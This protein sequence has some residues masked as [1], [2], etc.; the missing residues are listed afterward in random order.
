MSTFLQRTG[1]SIW[2]PAAKLDCCLDVRGPVAEEYALCEIE[3]EKLASLQRFSRFA[4][5]QG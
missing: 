2:K 1:R 4:F 3:L 5:C